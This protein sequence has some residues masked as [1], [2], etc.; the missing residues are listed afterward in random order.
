MTA[1]ERNDHVQY[2][3]LKRYDICEF[4]KKLIKCQGQKV[5]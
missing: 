3:R 5:M 2:K 4:F 1:V